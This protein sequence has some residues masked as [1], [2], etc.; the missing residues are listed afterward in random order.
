MNAGNT[1]RATS[2]DQLKEILQDIK[3]SKNL[4]SFNKALAFLGPFLI[5]GFDYFVP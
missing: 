4:V 2:D 5:F 1:K 3:T